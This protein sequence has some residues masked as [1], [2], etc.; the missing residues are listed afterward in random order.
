[1]ETYC[2]VITQIRPHSA[3]SY[4][5]TAPKANQAISGRPFFRLIASWSNIA[6]GTTTGGRPF[7]FSQL[8]RGWGFF[9]GKA[10]DLN[11]RR[12]QVSREKDDN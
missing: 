9:F 1:M 4:K 5:P 10:K 7:M 8:P 2:V 11:Y 6:D 12:Q 3:L